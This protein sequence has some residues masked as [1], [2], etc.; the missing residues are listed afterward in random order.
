MSRTFAF[1]ATIVSFC[2]DPVVAETLVGKW[3]CELG[4]EHLEIAGIGEYFAD[5]RV[6]MAAQTSGQ[7]DGITLEAEMTMTGTWQLDG[8]VFTDT[9]ETIK[10]EMLRLNGKNVAGSAFGKD[11]AETMIRNDG[12]ADFLR[13]PSEGKV[14]FIGVS[15]GTITT[16]YRKQSDYLGS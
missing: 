8:D 5:G 15:S 1:L 2:A 10:I 6:E 3:Y 9:A 4:D 7:K 14:H 13:F 16:C 12:E 11:L